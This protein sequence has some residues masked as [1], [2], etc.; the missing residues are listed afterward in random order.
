MTSSLRSSVVGLLALVLAACEISDDRA[1]ITAVAG[2]VL[3]DIQPTSIHEQREYCGSIARRTSGDLYA[4]VPIP[5]RTASC[6]AKPFYIYQ[7]YQTGDRLVANYHTHSNFSFIG[8]NE[9]PSVQDMVVTA[10]FNVPSYVATPGGRLWFIQADGSSAYQVCGVGCLPQD[11]NFFAWGGQIK[12][13]QRLTRV[14]LAHL[15]R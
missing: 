11:P 3:A 14:Q 9:V 6:P 5:G 1:D 15:L 2:A 13:P 10:H 4:T 7:T 12:V 8:Y